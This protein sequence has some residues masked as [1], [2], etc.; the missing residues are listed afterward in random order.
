MDVGVIGL[1]DIATK[2]YLPLLAARPD[3]RLHLA[4]RDERRRQEAATRF[5]AVS[6]SEDETG[7]LAH[8]L[9][10]VF[11]TAATSAHPRLVTAGLDAGAAVHVDKPL[12]DTGAEARSLVERA[13]S[14][15]VVLAV[16]F[17]RRFAPAYRRLAA[18]TDPPLVLMHKHRPDRPDAVRK[19]VF[20]DFIHVVDT[21]RWLLGT[22][23]TSIDVAGL[24]VDGQLHHVLLRLGAGGRHAIG[25]M[26]RVSGATTES[27]EVHG[28]GGT[29]VVHDVARTEE[30]R[31]D[32]VQL[33]RPGDWEPTLR[34][35]GFEAMVD[36]FLAT[37]GGARPEHPTLDDLLATHLL[38]ET[39][40]ERLEAL[41]GA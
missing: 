20:D 12:A 6:T 15:D 24:V 32:S 25:T 19:V 38:C 7:L 13:R 27:L 22:A 4:S 35:R 14:R 29:L 26:D 41:S 37:V 1:G 34:T 23:P 18:V 8:G 17:N 36:A 39:V 16:G 21:L 5:H 11:V 9:D 28:A 3:V 30:R 10:A 40:V 31:G 2:A 33:E